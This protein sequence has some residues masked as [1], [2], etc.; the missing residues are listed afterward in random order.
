MWI[1]CQADDSHEMSRV[2]I[3]YKKKKKKKIEWCPLQILLGALRDKMWLDNLACVCNIY[4]D[5]FCYIM[6]KAT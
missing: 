5:G 3:F 4:Q 1:I 2:I 6:L